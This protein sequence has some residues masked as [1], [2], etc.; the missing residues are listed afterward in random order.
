MLKSI[1]YLC[2][3]VLLLHAQDYKDF[4]IYQQKVTYEHI[5]DNLTLIEK[6]QQ[7]QDHYS[8]TK[9][10]LKIYASLEDKN[11]DKYEYQVQLA[12]QLPPQS[13]Q[14]NLQNMRIAI[15]PGH[16]GGD[17]CCFLESRYVW[18]DPKAVNGREDITFHEGQLALLTALHLQELLQKKGA[19]VMLTKKRLGESVYH[20]DFFTWL[21]EDFRNDVESYVSQISDLNERA[22]QRTWWLTRSHLW[23]IFRKFYNPLDLKARAAKINQFRPH[24]TIVIHYNVGAGNNENGQ[25]IGSNDNYNMAFIPGSFLKGEL[26]TATSRYHFLRLLLSSDLQNSLQLSQKVVEKFTEKLDVP[27]LVDSNKADYLHKYSLAT[28]APGVYARNLTLTRL[29]HGTI[30][31]GESLYQDNLKEAYLLAKK[32]DE[33]AGVKISHR[34]RL[35]AEAYFEAISSYCSK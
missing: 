31:Y 4:A 9:T 6:S 23:S 29:V 13:P 25:N 15:D 10:S 16:I 5:R 12:S 21:R 28:P 7:L 26:T 3:A 22:K 8:L 27:P 33:I 2:C 24:I 1:L 20:K 32:D 30:C 18:M 19:Q 11:K 17:T 34:V 35:V 14:K